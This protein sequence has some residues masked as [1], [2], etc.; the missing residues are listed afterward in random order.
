MAVLKEQGKSLQ[1]FGKCR[2]R[3]FASEDRPLFIRTLAFLMLMVT[4]STVRLYAQPQD[5][6]TEVQVK[7]AFLYNFAKFINWP[8]EVFS[9]EKAALVF[10]IL[11]EDPFG[12]TLA[13]MIKGK[14][15]N[16]RP[17]EIKRFK[18]LEDVGGCHIL[19]IS[20]SERKRLS[21]IRQAL[22]GASVLTVGD[23]EQFALEGGMISFT[24][25]DNKVRF[26]VNP[27]FA[28][29]AGLKISSKLLT[30]AKIVKR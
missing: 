15:V 27:D 16:G 26:Q 22:N 14:T 21:L 3:L 30:L 2:A 9:N 6:P 24:L 29:R 19:F 28:E 11:G 17:L 10:G 7:A 4:F 23:W 18:R 8:D 20:S 25:E 5:Q 13:Q 1:T 12:D